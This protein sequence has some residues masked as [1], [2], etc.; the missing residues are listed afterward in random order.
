MK[1]YKSIEMLQKLQIKHATFIGWLKVTKVLA[2][3]VI[4][5]K[6]VNADYEMCYNNE[7]CP[8]AR[9]FISQ[10]HDYYKSVFYH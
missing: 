7:K 9:N 6:D 8:A 5:R 3:A 10:F 2:A 4:S 1:V